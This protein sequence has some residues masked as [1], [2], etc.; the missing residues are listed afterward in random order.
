MSPY[1]ERLTGGAIVHFSPPFAFSRPPSFG[2]S[3]P[4]LPSPPDL[5]AHPVEFVNRLFCQ[6][7]TSL[8]GP[9]KKKRREI[10]A[11]PESGVTHYPDIPIVKA[12]SW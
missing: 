4:D 2:G 12:M 1:H 8:P 11:S 7:W 6:H 10:Q 3:L 9:E 5:P